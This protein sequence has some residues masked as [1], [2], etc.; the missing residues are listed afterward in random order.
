MMLIVAAG[1]VS[2]WKPSVNGTDQNHERNIM[3]NAMVDQWWRLRIAERCHVGTRSLRIESREAL[4]K[5]SPT[6]NL[7]MCLGK[8]HILV[9]YYLN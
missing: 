5:G 6:P 9:E 8:S 3:C 2:L 1:I 4:N 7:N